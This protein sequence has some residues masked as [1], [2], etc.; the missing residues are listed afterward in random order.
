[1]GVLYF[2]SYKVNKMN[3][4]LKNV[5]VSYKV[6]IL[7]SL[8]I[9]KLYFVHYSIKSS[10]FIRIILLR[11]TSK[12]AFFLKTANPTYV[13]AFTYLSKIRSISFVYGIE[14]SFAILFANTNTSS[15]CFRHRLQSSQSLMFSATSGGSSTSTGTSPPVMCWRLSSISAPSPRVCPLFCGIFTGKTKD[16]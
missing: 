16:H 2:Y 9:E 10:P 3:K 4:V 11:H 7:Q 13:Q 6:K 1:M 12:S 15:A 8:F 14:F 5:N